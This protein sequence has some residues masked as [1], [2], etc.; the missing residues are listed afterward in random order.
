[1]LGAGGDPRTGF[2]PL[3]TNAATFLTRIGNNPQVGS[4]PVAYRASRRE[5]DEATA[6]R[7]IE[8]AYGLLASIRLIP[9]GQTPAARE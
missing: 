2:L 5:E 9:L 7:L 8:E 3:V 1:L 4:R 6:R